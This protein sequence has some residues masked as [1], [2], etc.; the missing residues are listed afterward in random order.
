M[1]KAEFLDILRTKR[2]HLEENLAKLSAEQLTRRA[3]PGSWSIKDG[4]AHLTFYE[5]HMLNQ[6][7]RALQQEL[8]THNVTKA[9]Q[10]TRNAQIYERNQDRSL[11]EVLA[12]MQ[13][14]FAEVITLVEMIPETILIEPKYFAF[15]NGMPL[16]QYILDETSGEHYE[17]HLGALMV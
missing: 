11:T 17:E 9:E 15:L 12:E 4:L 14:S 8:E 16:W 2:T 6:V 5:Q 3:A 13:A 7:H 10:T 1:N